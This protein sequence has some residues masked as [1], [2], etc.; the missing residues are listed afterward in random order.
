MI[1]TIIFDLSEVY[2]KGLI[3]VGNYIQPIL[4]E[5]PKGI[6]S[7]LNNKDLTS[8]FHGEISEDEYWAR[9]INKN[10]WKVQPNI[11]KKAV[12]ANFKEIHGT[13][14]IIESLKE[15]GYRLGLLSVHTKEW[16]DYCDTKFDYHKLFDSISY[17]FEV[18]ISKPD[19]K[20]YEFILKK[21]KEKPEN[22]L[23]IDD[24]EENLVS[25][26]KLDIKTIQFK[27]PNQLKKDLILLSIK[28]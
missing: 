2:L 12:R 17:S 28:V 4:N 8:L 24:N 9:T 21:L 26:R 14:E 22:C 20:A 5:P 16:I 3:G 18:G 7:K 13:R 11:L 19:I 1:K 27:N 10:K 23:F 25:A 15:K 6:E